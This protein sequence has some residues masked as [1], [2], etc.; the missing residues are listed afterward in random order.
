MHKIGFIDIKGFRLCRDV[1]LPLEGF[2]PLVGPNNVGKSTIL[3]ALAWVLKPWALAESD[4][5]VSGRPV[6]VTARVDGITGEVLSRIPDRRHMAAIEPFCAGGS[7]WIRVTANAPGSKAISKEVYDHENYSGVEVPTAWREYPTGLPVAVSALLP[8]ALRIGAMEDLSEDLGKAKAG[9]TMRALL[10]EIMGPILDAHV[11]LCDAMAVVQRI[12]RA[13][14][15]ARS[16]H[17]KTFDRAASDALAGFFPGLSIELDLQLVEIKEFFK[18][19]ELYITDAATGDRR[20]FDQ[21]GTGA[22]RAIQMALIRHLADLRAGATLGAARRLLLIDEPELY[23]HPQGAR[24]LRHA[25]AALSEGG[26]QV[27]YSTHSPLMLSREN[28][29]DTVIVSRDKEAGTLTRQPLRQ[30][31]AASLQEA[32]A[33]SRTLFELGNLAEIY[34]STLVVL[35]EGKTDRRLLPLVYERLFGHHPELDQIAFVSI[36]ACSDIPKAL[37]VLSAMGIQAR[38]IVDLDFAFTEARKGS[39]AMLPKEDDFLKTSRAV[40]K[41]L[42]AVHNFPIGE[43]G[44]PIK[45]KKTGWQ[46]A[47]AWSLFAADAEGKRLVA[48]VQQALKEEGVWVWSA[49]CIEDITGHRNKGEDAILAQEVSIGALSAAEIALAMEEFPR[50]FRWLREALAA[51]EL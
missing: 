26:F 28:A 2:T 5:A 50:C 12:L 37:P 36:G 34:F 27:V 32:E 46:A 15:D 24:R 21:L 45:D 13:D 19:G 7:L 6:V 10:D 25:L 4:F 43:N 51:S 38:A 17:L 35:C 20:R 47:N 40:L 33:Q 29:A 3:T 11:E 9:S 41:R 39:N 44:L 49:G 1:A 30:A 42:Q 31:V 8:E 14:G 16:E 22:Q 23:L 48:Q 18:A